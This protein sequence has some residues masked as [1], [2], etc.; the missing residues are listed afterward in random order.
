MASNGA[1][2]GNSD[3]AYLPVGWTVQVLLNSATQNL[4]YDV[5]APSTVYVPMA[6]A[7]PA[8]V[9]APTE[10]VVEG[11]VPAGVVG[12]VQADDAPPEKVDAGVTVMATI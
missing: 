2:A 10:A 6:E 1:Q 8:A 7:P 3:Y 4:G 12:S 11:D 5:T 9:E